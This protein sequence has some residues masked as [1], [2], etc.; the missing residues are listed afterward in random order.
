MV[1][2]EIKQSIGRYAGC[3]SLIIFC[4]VLFVVSVFMCCRHKNLKEPEVFYHI[5]GNK[6]QELIDKEGPASIKPIPS[7]KGMNGIKR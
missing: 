7:P 5:Q 4:I 6:L 1:P 2:E 3:M